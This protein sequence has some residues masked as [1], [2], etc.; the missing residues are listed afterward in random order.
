[1][2]NVFFLGV[3]AQK[4]GT[5][6]LYQ[7][8]S[9]QPGFNLGV[10]KEYHIWDALYVEECRRFMSAREGSLRYRMQNVKGA[11]ERYFAGL[12]SEKVRCTG[13]ITPSYA[14]L[15]AAAFETIRRRLE[16]AGFQLKVI[17]LLR[18][19]FDRC[20]SAVRMSIRKGRQVDDESTALRDAYRTRDFVLRTDYKR[21]IQNIEAVF[22]PENVHYAIFEELF[23][24]HAIGALSAFCGVSPIAG[25][26]EK[27]FNVSVKSD[28][29]AEALR[30]EIREFYA[31]VYG[32]CHER[33]PQTRMLWSPGPRSD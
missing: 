7:F 1:M 9:S 13:D 19:P 33:F 21:T 15:S 12:L 31:E 3:G 30:G 32:L 24:P 14:G 2:R 23:T 20:W 5:T 27:T 25:F 11:Y 8:L 4:A 10:R 17:F 18:D 22:E 29:A 26:A 28:R 16:A 6:W